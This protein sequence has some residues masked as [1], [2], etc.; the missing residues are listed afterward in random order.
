M[1]GC[2]TVNVNCGSDASSI[3]DCVLAVSI[4][5]SFT[6]SLAVEDTVRL[7]RLLP[8]I[9]IMMMIILMILITG[10]A[11]LVLGLEKE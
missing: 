10:L 6:I 7:G 4:I 11:Y 2:D 3:N 1:G 5:G 9:I 8:I